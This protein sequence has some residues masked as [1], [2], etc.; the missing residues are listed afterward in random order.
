[1]YNHVQ[2][3]LMVITR[4]QHF[5]DHHLVSIMSWKKHAA[6]FLQLGAPQGFSF[7]LWEVGDMAPFSEVLCCRIGYSD[8]T[9]WEGGFETW[10]TWQNV[11]TFRFPS[12]KTMMCLQMLHWSLKSFNTW[13]FTTGEVSDSLPYDMLMLGVYPSRKSNVWKNV[14]SKRNEH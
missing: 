10:E 11:A 12:G 9:T 2:R 6:L 5:Y 1:M 14:A 4:I 7:Q 13:R 8:L 3:I